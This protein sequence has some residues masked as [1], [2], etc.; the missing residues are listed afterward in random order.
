MGPGNR[1]GNEASDLNRQVPSQRQWNSAAQ[2][3]GEL[4][5]DRTRRCRPSPRIANFRVRSLSPR[6][7]RFPVDRTTAVG[8]AVHALV[9]VSWRGGYLADMY[10]PRGQIAHSATAASN[11]RLT[12]KRGPLS[13]LTRNQL[14]QNC[15]LESS[16]LMAEMPPCATRRK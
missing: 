4:T 12:C 9:S 10:A 5:T 6:H 8:R 3:K 13:F 1:L 7:S 11:Q 2:T 16:E 14:R 15:R